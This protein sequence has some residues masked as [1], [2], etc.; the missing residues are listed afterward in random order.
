MRT[1]PLL[2]VLIALAV[3]AG[4]C[5]RED[6]AVQDARTAIAHLDLARAERCLQGVDSEEASQLRAEIRKLRQRE[7]EAPAQAAPLPF[8]RP[9]APIKSGATPSAGLARKPSATADERVVRAPLPI[10]SAD[11]QAESASESDSGEPAA[12]PVDESPLGQML[13]RARTSLEKK[14]WVQGLAVLDEAQAASGNRESEVAEVRQELLSAALEDSDALLARV[15]QIERSGR[16]Q[17]AWQ[18]LAQE[19][20]RF[21]EDGEFILF[22]REVENLRIRVGAAPLAPR[23]ASSQPKR[24]TSAIAAALAKMSATEREAAAREWEAAGDFEAARAAWLAAG[25]KLSFGEE[26][27]R[28]FGHASD[29]LGRIALRT[30]LSEA[31]RADSRVLTEAGISANGAGSPVVDGERTSWE[32]LPLATLLRAAALVEL[33][34]AARKGVLWERILRGGPKEKERALEELGQWQE[35]GDISAADAAGMV[36]RAR[37]ESAKGGWT[38]KDGKWIGAADAAADERKKELARLAQIFSQAHPEERDA[39]FAELVATDDEELI[40]AALEERWNKHARTL[41]KSATLRELEQL[42]E[43]RRELDV[44]RKAALALI[45]DEEE[46]FYPY[47]PPECPPEKAAKYAGVQRRV[48]ELVD[49]VRTVWK[50]SRPVRIPEPV[51]EALDELAWNREHQE[52][53][54][55]S[56]D[57][58]KE[59]PAFVFGL[60]AK[61]AEVGLAE[62]AWDAGEQAEL[63]TSRKVVALNERLFTQAEASKTGDPAAIPNTEE[64]EQVRVTNA[65]RALMGRRALAW[66]AKLQIAAQGHSEY[67]A[68][69]G[70]FGHTEKG[71]PGRETPFDRMKQAG[72][73]AGVSENCSMN[74]TDPEGTHVGWMHSSGHHRNLLM[75]GHREMASGLASSYWTQNFGTGKSFEALLDAP[76]SEPAPRGR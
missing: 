45:F 61:L 14:Q 59:V 36:A 23:V 18:T 57:L 13:A 42:A 21:P 46:Y 15:S 62:F 10:A 32:K 41:A 27:D 35:R 2:V 11:E 55:I 56:F 65:Y 1:A 7:S 19:A 73:E 28:A 58:P 8:G 63:A 72:Y 44:A 49:A 3:G 22:Q 52:A 20:Q 33:S 76:A 9:A 34:D 54:E 16:A 66:N 69:T 29:L 47:N 75:A 5:A 24:P 30:E 70:D 25:E 67:M 60:P 68:N 26:R 6:A 43:L 37:T 53:L 64:R 51:R 50:R 12:K 40:A 71:R 17:Q 74:Q 4:S 39:A 38:Y 31:L 48:D